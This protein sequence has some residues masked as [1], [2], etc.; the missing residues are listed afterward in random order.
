MSLSEVIA[1]GP[2]G[3]GGDPAMSLQGCADCGPVRG[4]PVVEMRM[5]ALAGRREQYRQMR[6]TRATRMGEVIHWAP[7]GPGGDPQMS[8]QGLGAL[9]PG[10]QAQADAAMGQ[11]E[12]T[13]A[14]VFNEIAEA[15]AAGADE[16]EVVH[17]QNAY[18]GLLDRMIGA[19]IATVD[20]DDDGWPGLRDELAQLDADYR[21][22]LGQ[23]LEARE[24]RR[25]GNRA[26]G[27]AWGV[28][29]AVVTAGV[30]GAVWYNRKRRKR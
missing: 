9:S 7:L 28:G 19:Q 1:W 25:F 2:L 20:I 18:V 30:L 17:Y 5:G 16:G 26:A 15:Y 23:L 3:P 21:T 6:G 27:L 24:A 8:L 13:D 4:A 22:L 29:A 12:A 14:Q 11:L 10:A